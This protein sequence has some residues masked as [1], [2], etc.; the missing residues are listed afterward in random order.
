MTRCQSNSAILENNYAIARLTHPEVAII[1]AGL[2]DT[3]SRFWILNF[4]FTNTNS[5]GVPAFAFVLHLL[6]LLREMACLTPMAIAQ[7][8]KSTR[9]R[10]DTSR[11]Y[12]NLYHECQES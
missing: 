6:Y 5:E 9:S 7:V 8:S 3:D 12:L 10:H 2:L 1:A 11:Q 4:G